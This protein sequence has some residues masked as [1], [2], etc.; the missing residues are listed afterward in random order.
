LYQILK[1]A[2]TLNFSLPPQGREQGEDTTNEFFWA[3][4]KQEDA[5]EKGLQRRRR[6]DA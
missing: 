5:H 3:Y 6:D 1:D 4:L 2:G